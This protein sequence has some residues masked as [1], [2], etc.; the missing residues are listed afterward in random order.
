MTKA[1]KIQLE[2]AVTDRTQAGLSSAKNSVAQFGRE[3][4]RATEQAANSFQNIGEAAAKAQKKVD[5]S[6]RSLIALIQ[7]LSAE[8]QAGGKNTEAYVLALAQQRGIKPEVLEPYLKVL[9]E[10]RAAQD[11]AAQSM[12]AMGLTA[13]QTAAALR[14]VP[15]QLTDIVVSLAGGQSVMQVF[16]QQG[17][18]LRDIFGSAGAAAQ[19]LGRHVVGLITPLNVGLAAVG[20]LGAALYS[21]QK[22]AQELSKALVLT[23]GA[24]GVSAGQL[25]QIAAA[26]DTVAGTQSHAAE[27]LV[28]FVRA[29]IQGRE[30]LQEFAAAAIRFEQATGQAVETT[31]KQFAALAKE[32]LRAS[33]EL[34]ESMNY[35]TASTYEQI[36]ALME[37]GRVT[38]AARVAQEAFAE[39]IDSRASQVDANLNLFA[40]GWRE[41]ASAVKEA[42]DEV[43]HWLDGVAGIRNPYRD[44]EAARKHLAVYLEE[45]KRSP[46]NQFLYQDQINATKERIRVL[47]EQIQ[48]EEEIAAQQRAQ[49]DMV[50][51]RAKFDQ[52]GL[53]FLSQREKMEREIAAATELALRAGVSREELERRIAAIRA[54]YEKPDRG[55]SGGSEESRELRERTKLLNQLAGITD[56]YYEQLARIQAMRREGLITDQQQIQLLD[57]L[58]KR[59]PFAIKQAKELAAAEAERKKQ[60]DAVWNAVHATE[61][62]A[63]AQEQANA[64]F[65]QGK[66]A[67]AELTLAELE[68]QR[69]AME[70]ATNVVPGY[71]EALDARIAA[72]R[73]L[74]AALKAHEV[75]E[76]AAES[77]QQAQREWE[78]TA[79]NIERS[80]TDALMRGFES[81]KDFAR[82]LRD[83]IVN[84]F[85]TLVLRPIIQA[86]VMPVAGGLAG[87]FSMPGTAAAAPTDLFGGLKAVYDV[88]R[89]GSMFAPKGL[90]SSIPGGAFISGLLSTK[91]PGTVALSG[92]AMSLAAGGTAGGPVASLA[93]AENLAGLT[94]GGLTIG[95]ALGMGAL[96]GLGYSL[97]GGSLGLPQNQYSGITA[98]LGGALGAWGGSALASSTAG[99]ALGATAGSALPVVGTAAGAVLGGLASSLFSGD[100]RSPSVIFNAQRIQ[101]GNID[102]ERIGGGNFRAGFEFHTK[103]GADYAA[104]E[105]IA[106]AL[107]QVAAQQFAEVEAA[108][109]AFGDK[110]VDML[111][112]T[113][114]EFGRKV[115]GA[116]GGAWDFGSDMELDELLAKY[117]DGLRKAIL[118]AAEDAFEAAGTDLVSS[119]TYAE[120]LALVA[121]RAEEAIK[122][123]Q[124]T[125][126]AGVQSGDVEAYAAALQQLNATINT[127]TATWE[128]ISRAAD[129][130]VKP[131]TAYELAV[132][133]ANAQFDEWIDT[134]SALGFAQGKIEELEA[135]RAA[136]LARLDREMGPI[137]DAE[138]ARKDAIA[139]AEAAVETARKNLIDAYEREADELRQ[140][141]ERWEQFAKSLKQWRESALTGRQSPLSPL[142]QRELVSQRYQDVLLRSRIGD[143][144]AIEELQDV[145]AEQLASQLE[146]AETAEDYARTAM[147]TLAEV[148]SVEQLATR[149]A[150]AAERQLEALQQQ[151]SQLIEINQSV[152]SVKDAI[153]AL[154]AA[155]ASAAAAQASA[156]AAQNAVSNGGFDPA[157][158][159]R[160]K[161]AS[162][163]ASGAKVSWYTPP[164]GTWTEADTLAAIT[165]AGMT[166]EEHYL[167]Y[168][169]KEGIKGYA[170]GGFHPGGLRLVGEEGPELEVTGP[171]RIWSARETKEILAGGA[172]TS[173]EVRALREELRA[174]GSALAR[175]TMETAQLLRR[176]DG[177]G[178]PEVRSVA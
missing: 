59:Q 24:A 116:G 148:E 33:L 128:Q 118:E 81:G 131:P 165:L 140:T 109:G 5:A 125:I 57:E 112:E 72:Q 121:G 135:K 100:E 101:W 35:L 143:I 127:I 151:V 145:A 31:A 97:L 45:A 64:V 7:R 146:T 111:R 85:Q 39:A 67:L 103:D 18:Q 122:G 152:L 106:A 82:N 4:A 84:M 155:Q 126:S 12:H 95:A 29:G 139:K 142:A 37:Q 113:T 115:A 20:A 178:M 55:A 80:L 58:T 49:A 15:M 169:I 96:G 48:K 91:L 153:A 162:L 74:V 160:N 93:A 50:K 78:R 65:G 26:I 94:G 62:Q 36:K 70:T 164:S 171:A 38:E 23:G 10:A 43:V 154:Q 47:E 79:K 124:E 53:K 66:A 144:A 120:A 75:K 99:A 138:A 8:A 69:A 54:S 28:E 42:W 130:L 51:A 2:V 89:S 44:L 175:N 158:Y 161:T 174:I 87:A 110:Y 163:N 136:T 1:R 102:A 137:A 68:Q 176:W 11:A 104:G 156:A 107:E 168:G 159:L 52:D 34:N 73:R 30:A 177:D 92:G 16:L 19:A 77:A 172:A 61:R 88:A 150:S 123:L 114:I 9:R 147:R 167:K 46:L 56:D 166:L 170:S 98:S 22:Q 17:G 13:K 86:I 21:A 133:Q 71:I 157:A 129:D 90:F 119:S 63:K 132:R 60:L 105:Q 108:V 117:S 141:K 32:P 3:T 41:I 27:T 14:Q 173:E 149:Q 6:T 134:L 25:S 40:R 83:A 76:A